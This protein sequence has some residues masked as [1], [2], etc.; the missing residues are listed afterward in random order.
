MKNFP[1]RSSDLTHLYSLCIDNLCSNLKL[2]TLEVIVTKANFDDKSYLTENLFEI[3]MD[4][5]T[6]V[7]MRWLR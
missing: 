1:E 3:C 4:I 5:R 7:I 6:S 2:S